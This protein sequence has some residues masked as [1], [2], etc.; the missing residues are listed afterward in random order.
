MQLGLTTVLVLS[1]CTKLSDLHHYAF[2]PT[3]MVETI[4]DLLTHEAFGATLLDP[5]HRRRSTVPPRL[6]PATM[7]L[8]IPEV[9]ESQP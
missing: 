7:Q 3:Y 8:R 6:L 9:R 4:A 2:R 1:G 5:A